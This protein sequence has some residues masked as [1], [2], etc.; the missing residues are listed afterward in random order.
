M[1]V[2]SFI[3]VWIHNFFLV[4]KSVKR[5]EIKVEQDVMKYLPTFLKSQDDRSPTRRVAPSV[6]RRVRWKCTLKQFDHKRIRKTLSTLACNQRRSRY[7]PALTQLSSPTG[8]YFIVWKI[9]ILVSSPFS[10]KEYAKWFEM[11]LLI[12]NSN[13]TLSSGI[14]NTFA[15]VGLDPLLSWLFWL[16]LLKFNCYI[17]RARCSIVSNNTQ[18]SKC[19]MVACE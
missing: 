3:S 8:K 18:F 2:N 6:I 11:R 1:I 12:F 9:I 5:R 17:G 15:A 13:G 4:E 16:H 14:E 7:R 10:V 19:F